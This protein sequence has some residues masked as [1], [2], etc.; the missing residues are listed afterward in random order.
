[1]EHF[2]IQMEKKLLVNGKKGNLYSGIFRNQSFV[3]FSLL[4]GSNSAP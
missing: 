3:M 2:L 4:I 1:M